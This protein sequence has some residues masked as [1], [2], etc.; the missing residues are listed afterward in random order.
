[1]CQVQRK[2]HSPKFWQFGKSQHCSG[3]CEASSPLTKMS[4]PHLCQ[5]EQMA[6]CG[7]YE[8]SKAHDG[9][10][11]HSTSQ[12]PGYTSEY[13]TDLLAF[14]NPNPFPKPLQ[15]MGFPLDSYSFWL[16]TLLFWLCFLS[17]SSSLSSLSCYPSPILCLYLLLSFQCFSHGQVQSTGHVQPITF[18]P[19]CGLF[20]MSLIYNKTLSLNQILEWPCPQFIQVAD[21]IYTQ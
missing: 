5:K 12:V 7:A 11:G 18:S 8:H 1:M 2:L 16:L 9:L 10:Q 3:M 13:I 4:F 15:L 19:C 6:I 20:Q 21:C 17:F 14:L